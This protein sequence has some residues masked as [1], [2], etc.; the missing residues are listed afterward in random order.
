MTIAGIMGGSM[1]SL[2]TALRANCTMMELALPDWQRR[3]LR[4]M[5]DDGIVSFGY[6]F[7]V[8]DI[9]CVMHAHC[10]VETVSGLGFQL[11]WEAHYK[12]TS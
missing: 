2:H 9:E 3:G 4:T 7:R 12:L 1:T 5:H 11:L 8:W 10:R 6:L